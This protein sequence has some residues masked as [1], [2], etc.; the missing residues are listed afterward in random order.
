[1]KKRVRIFSYVRET[2]V[3]EYSDYPCTA[4]IEDGQAAESGGAYRKDGGRI[5]LM[6]RAEARVKPGDYASFDM[7][8][9]VPDKGRDYIITAVRDN[10]RGGLPHW[11]LIV[12]G[13]VRGQ[14]Q[15]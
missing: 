13:R 2:G 5:R 4:A 8:R 11:R 3:Y 9:E 7:E 10:R 12:N 14:S 1:M 6:T 15:Y